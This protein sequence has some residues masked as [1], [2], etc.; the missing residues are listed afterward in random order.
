MNNRSKERML[1]V[2]VTLA[3]SAIMF[4]TYSFF[5]SFETKADALDKYGR[6]ETKIDLMLCYLK[7][8]KHCV[9]DRK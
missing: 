1:G 4:L 7:P 5:G 8:E 6:L 2:V 3:S 9:K